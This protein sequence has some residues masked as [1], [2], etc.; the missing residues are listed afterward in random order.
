MFVKRKRDEPAVGTAGGSSLCEKASGIRFS[1][2][3][4]SDFHPPA[5]FVNRG[6]R[7]LLSRTETVTFS[8]E[9]S[10]RKMNQPGIA[11]Q[12]LQ[13]GTCTWRGSALCADSGIGNPFLTE[14]ESYRGFSPSGIHGTSFAFAHPEVSF[15]PAE[16]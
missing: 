9:I 2:K 15:R 4:R 6:S 3:G 1:K 16:G 11:E 8:P 13:N 7:F 5:P 10:V 12:K 14:R